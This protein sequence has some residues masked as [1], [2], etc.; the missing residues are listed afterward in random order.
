V[1]KSHD[2]TRVTL[3]AFTHSLFQVMPFCTLHPYMPLV[4][5]EPTGCRKWCESEKAYFNWDSTSGSSTWCLSPE[6]RTPE[7]FPGLV[8]RILTFTCDEG[9]TITSLYFYLAGFQRLRIMSHRDPCHRLSNLY[10]NALRATPLTF[11]A[12]LSSLTI[13]KYKRAPYGQFDGKHSL[14]VPSAPI[15]KHG[16]C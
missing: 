10:I 1:S 8:Q 12:V 11:D 14:P 5:D 7:A 16:L 3:L 15:C 9:S 4:I 13:H 2:S 6:L